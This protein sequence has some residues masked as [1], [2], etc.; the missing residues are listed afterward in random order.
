MNLLAVKK[1]SLIGGILLFYALPAYASFEITEIMYDLDGTDTDREWVEVQNTGATAEDL[2]LWSFFSANTRHSLVPDTVSLVPAGGYA[3]IAQKAAKF[4]IDW[5]NYSGLLFDSSWTG[6]NNTTDTVALKDPNANLVSSFTYTSSMGA[7]GDGNTLQKNN[8]VWSGGAPTPGAAPL[9]SVTPANNASPSNTNNNGSPNTTTSTPSGGG[10]GVSASVYASKKEE[11]IPKI[12]TDIIVKNIVMARVGFSISSHTTGL[13]KEVLTHGKYIWN[14]GDGMSREE[15]D[16]VPFTYVY[17][18]PGDYVLSLSY[19]PNYYKTEPDAVDRVIIKV[20][21]EG[22]SIN[23]VGDASDPY[24][25]LQNKSSYEVA[26]SKW[27]IKGVTH[28]FT[29][30]EGT[31]LL[32]NSTLKLSPRLTLFDVNDLK[33]LSLENPNTEVVST[34]PAV[35]PKQNK[36]FSHTDSVNIDYKQKDSSFSKDNNQIIDLNNLGASAAKAETNFNLSP[37]YAWFGLGG[38]VMLGG[39][40]TVFSRHPKTVKD[41]LEKKVQASDI[42][43]IE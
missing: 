42:T 8:G 20:I 1:Y 43:I 5:P 12:S 9:G 28:S 35:T 2:S 32:P 11:A 27:I 14:F 18:Y 13:S 26:I 17:D 40:A 16:A 24:V 30:P 7:A 37:Y 38:L 39:L 33:A 4:K 21:D 19:S 34:Y 22:V 31:I 3:V 41:S 36:L 10:G 25:A 6:L 29:I 23:N 15:T